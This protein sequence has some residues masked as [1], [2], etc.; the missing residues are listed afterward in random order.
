MAIC[1][2]NFMSYYKNEATAIDFLIAFLFSCKSTK[3]GNNILWE[4]VNKKHSVNKNTFNKNLKRLKEKGII[5][6]DKGSIEINSKKLS[7]FYKYKIIY[8]KPESSSKIIMIFDIPEKERATR[9]WLRGQIKFW[10][11]KMIQKSVWL[12]MGPLPK[13]FYERIKMLN[14]DKNIKVFNVQQKVRDI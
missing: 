14:L 10:N 2:E 1:P 6:V 4:R 7:N 13:E 8:S 11:F 3:I 9:D 12:G 5:K